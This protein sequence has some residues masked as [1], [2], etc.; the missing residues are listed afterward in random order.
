MDTLAFF[1]IISTLFKKK[2]IILELIGCNSKLES[3]PHYFE[4]VVKLMFLVWARE[5]QVISKISHGKYG[6]SLTSPHHPPQP[7]PN[8]PHQ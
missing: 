8:S 4:Q 6:D 1:T 7:Q 3:L 2:I 5:C